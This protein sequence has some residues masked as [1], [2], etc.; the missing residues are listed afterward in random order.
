M[1]KRLFIDHKNVILRTTERFFENPKMVIRYRC[2]TIAVF[3]RVRLG[4]YSKVQLV[5]IS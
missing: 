3:L 2:E 4:L 1:F 5:N